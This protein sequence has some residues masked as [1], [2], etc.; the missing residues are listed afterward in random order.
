MKQVHRTSIYFCTSSER[1]Y[2]TRARAGIIGPDY[3]PQT[4]LGRVCHNEASASPISLSSVARVGAY[5]AN[6]SPRGGIEVT[7]TREEQVTK[8]PG[9]AMTEKLATVAAVLR[10]VDFILTKENHSLFSECLSRHIRFRR[11]I[12]L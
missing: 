5:V 7:R 3:T 11:A 6:R 10:R 1:T 12:E 9:A 2:A 4:S 8:S